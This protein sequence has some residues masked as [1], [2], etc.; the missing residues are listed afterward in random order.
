MLLPG[1]AELRASLS[2]NEDSPTAPFLQLCPG[3]KIEDE[4]VHHGDLE[5]KF[6][7]SVFLTQLF[8]HQFFPFSLVVYIP[9][10]GLT[11]ARNQGFIGPNFFVSWFIPTV[12]FITTY[13]THDIV[14]REEFNRSTKTKTMGVILSAWG[15][16]TARNIVVAF[17]YAYYTVHEYQQVHNSVRDSAQNEQLQLL[18]W[19]AP[20][21]GK[22]A[23]ELRHA[24]IEQGVSFCDSQFAFSCRQASDQRSR[25][26]SKKFKLLMFPTA[27]VQEGIHSLLVAPEYTE[28]RSSN[29]QYLATHPRQTRISATVFCAAVA[30][31]AVLS[32]SGHTTRSFV[33]SARWRLK[34]RAVG[35]LIAA[36]PLSF[37]LAFSQP[38]HDA[39]HENAHGTHILFDSEH[40]IVIVANFLG[41]LLLASL[42]GALKMFFFGP[43]SSVHSSHT[44]RALFTHSPH[45]LPISPHTLL[46][47][48][49]SPHTLSSSTLHLPTHS[50]HLLSISPH[51]LLIYSP[52]PHTLSS[53]TL[54]LLTHSPH[55]S[56]SPR[57]LSSSTLHL[58]THSPH[59]SISPHAPPSGVLIMFFWVGT[60][61]FERRFIMLDTVS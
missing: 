1:E 39:S 55:L 7:L 52:S 37:N 59:L 22:L 12:L 27:E 3:D 46:I 15:S 45:L 17:K 20:S 34:V 47:Y 35:I 31:Q 25:E 5:S 48:S 18:F 4:F 38:D 41:F 54:H 58:P 11:F 23:H 9:V 42:N 44:P 19:A 61:D 28:Q 8:Y 60:L 43:L 14:M 2:L 36:L 13:L 30:Y 6:T 21:L 32:Q 29:D 40:V 16:Y 56:P 51:T 50:P 49:P 26:L 10:E 53:S 33:S 57:S 24:A